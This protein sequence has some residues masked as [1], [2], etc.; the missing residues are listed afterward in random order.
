M[1]V[2]AAVVVEGEPCGAGCECALD[3]ESK[4]EVMYLR[5]V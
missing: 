3:G 1:E 2:V 5:R 4:R